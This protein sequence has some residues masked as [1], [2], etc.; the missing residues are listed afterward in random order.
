MSQITDELMGHAADNDGIEEYDNP[1]PRW[2]LGLFYLTII[3]AGFYAVKYHFVDHDSQL[4]RYDRQMAAAAEMWPQSDEAAPVVV[5]AE[6][7]AAGKEIF[8][9]TCA[10]CH[11]QGGEGGIGAK[12]ID[13]E[14]IHGGKP[15]QIQHTITN[16]VIEKGMP[17]WGPVLGPEKVAQVAAFVVDL[18]AKS[19]AGFAEP[20]AAAEEPAPTA[21]P[22]ADADPLVA[23]EQIW[24]QYCVACHGPEGEGTVTAPSLVDDE[25]LH[26]SDMDQIVHTITNGVEGKAM[27]AWEPVLGEAGVK[28]VATY[29]HHRAFGDDE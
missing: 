4:Q 18:H 23:G 15:E 3:W 16:G 6:T 12:L 1:L 9:T 5:N 10:S 17:A 13:A 8:T 20:S 11:G 19:G 27:V 22:D 26:G 14:W 24:N 21:L 29:V 25:W 7:I 2:W 28:Q